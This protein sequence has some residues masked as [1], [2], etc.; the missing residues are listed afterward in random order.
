MIDD[1]LKFIFIHIPKTGGSSIEQI[2]GRENRL[3]DKTVHAPLSVY[4]LEKYKAI[5]PC[6][7]KNKG[8]TNL[9]GMNIKNY[10]DINKII[11]KKFLGIFL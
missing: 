3:K 2:F 1:E 8:I 11:I 6:G 10:S 7:I 5:I 4:D 9:K